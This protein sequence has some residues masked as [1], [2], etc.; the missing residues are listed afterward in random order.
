MSASAMVPG[1]ACECQ[2]EKNTHRSVSAKEQHQKHAIL[3]YS[4]P[5]QGEAVT[6]TEERTYFCDD[7]VAGGHPLLHLCLE[8]SDLMK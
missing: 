1:P 4:D 6:D 8:P 2:G 5:T 7:A 3:Y